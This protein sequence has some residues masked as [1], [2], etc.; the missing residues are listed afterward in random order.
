MMLIMI[1]GLPGSGKTTFGLGL[2]NSINAVHLNTDI[3]RNNMGRRGK[4]DEVS[5][6]MIYAKMLKQTESYL[7]RGE[8]VIVDATFY[9]AALRKPYQRLAKKYKKRLYWI[10]LTAEESV[11]K[12]RIGQRKQYNEADFEVY[13]TLKAIYEPLEEDHIVLHSD[14][15]TLEKIIAK[16]RVYLS[17]APTQISLH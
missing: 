9:K 16:A 5:K 3:I 1:T 7:H 2:A 11:V 4:H 17:L 15:D 13:L 14:T 6:S 10:V 8:D 12:K